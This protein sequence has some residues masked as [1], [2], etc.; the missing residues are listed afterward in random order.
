MLQK[1]DIVSARTAR[2]GEEEWHRLADDTS[3]LPF[4]AVL[5]GRMNPGI[6]GRMALGLALGA[7]L[8]VWFLLHGHEAIIGVDPMGLV[9]P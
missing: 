6:D 9:E 3:V 4:G 8:Y 5:S 7:V 1:P 2:L